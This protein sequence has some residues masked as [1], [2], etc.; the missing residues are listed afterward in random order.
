LAAPY[1][2]HFSAAIAEIFFLNGR[3]VSKD[4]ENASLIPHRRTNYRKAPLRRRITT[5]TRKKCKKDLTQSKKTRS[6][7]SGVHLAADVVAVATAVTPP[8]GN[9]VG[10]CDE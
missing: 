10:Q 7:P 6:G 3:R 2:K 4:P 8:P 9:E 5:H 1:S